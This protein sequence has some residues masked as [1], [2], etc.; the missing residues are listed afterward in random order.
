MAIR[1]WAVWERNKI[2]GIV[3]F[4]EGAISIVFVLYTGSAYGNSLTC[5]SVK[6]QR[7]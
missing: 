4:T 7:P 3:L 6:L 5:E 2:V 1:T